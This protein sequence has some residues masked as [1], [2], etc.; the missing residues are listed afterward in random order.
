MF[1]LFYSI[2]LFFCYLQI[3]FLFT[4]QARIPPGLFNVLSLVIVVRPLG[5]RPLCVGVGLCVFVRLFLFLCL[6]VFL[7]VY[8]C[9][10]RVC[11]FVCVFVLCL[12][13]DVA[14]WRDGDGLHQ[15]CRGGVA[16]FIV[17]HIFENMSEKHEKGVPK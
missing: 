16:D 3:S 8:A 10:L 2:F 4:A 6:C 15:A 5:R 1:P 14:R 7:C 12:H 13:D 11:V 9:V 17:L